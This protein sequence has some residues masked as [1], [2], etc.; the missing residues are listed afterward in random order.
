MVLVLPEA[1]YLGRQGATAFF[2]LPQPHHTG[3][4]Q[5]EAEDDIW[6]S[7][8]TSRG[9]LVHSSM[10]VFMISVVDKEEKG[11]TSSEPWKLHTRV[12]TGKNIGK[13]CQVTPSR[14]CRL[15]HGPSLLPDVGQGAA[16]PLKN[17]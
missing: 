2:S 14:C 7:E 3:K 5:G 12:K 15:I 6:M 13:E 1:T 16:R 9:A 17:E 11:E 10:E 4:C 8:I